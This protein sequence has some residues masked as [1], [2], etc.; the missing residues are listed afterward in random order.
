[1]AAEVTTRLKRNLDSLLA[2][3]E[4]TTDEFTA[5]NHSFMAGQM[6]YY[7][8]MVVDDSTY[9]S[10]YDIATLETE[11]W[12]RRAAAI[13]LAFGGYPAALNR[14]IDEMKDAIAGGDFCLARKNIAIELG[15]YGDQRLD[16]RD[17]TLDL[18]G[19][20]CERLVTRLC[21]ELCSDAEM[22][23]R[24]MALFDI[25]YLSQHRSVSEASFESTLLQ[26]KAVLGKAL[27]RMESERNAIDF[28]EVREVRSILGLRALE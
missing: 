20:S 25:I 6:A 21:S 7:L 26:C 15:F 27:D 23:N 12:I 9:S 19:Q 3:R 17:P 8:G 24:R 13:G 28:P 11:F 18:G 14:L 4:G 5:R 1:M 10:L 16:P 22:P 2:A